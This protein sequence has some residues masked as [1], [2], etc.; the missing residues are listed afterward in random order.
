L[1][2]E[3]VKGGLSRD[4]FLQ[5]RQDA[6]TEIRNVLIRFQVISPFDQQKS[7]A[8]S[9]PY[10][11]YLEI[12]SHGDELTAS[13]DGNNITVPR[14]N[15]LNAIHLIRRNLYRG[16]QFSSFDTQSP[17]MNKDIAYSFRF[18]KQR[19]DSRRDLAAMD[20]LYMLERAVEP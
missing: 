6:T 4:P 13:I 10:A 15:F 7:L 3:I 12:V 8:I 5:S 9:N 20:A 1:T 17:W 19:L 11:V 18:I 2:N 16:E 14:R